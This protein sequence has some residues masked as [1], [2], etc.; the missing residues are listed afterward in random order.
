[1]RG[2]VLVKGGMMLLRRELSEGKG[3]DWVNGREA[4]CIWPYVFEWVEVG[5]VET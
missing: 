3:V 4:M 5:L 1:M 2:M